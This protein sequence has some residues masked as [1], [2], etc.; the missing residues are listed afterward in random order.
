MTGL[1]VPFGLGET[2]AA[3]ATNSRPAAHA[4]VDTAAGPPVAAIGS[5]QVAPGL[6]DAA[7]AATTIELLSPQVEAGARG[8]PVIAGQRASAQQREEVG[9]T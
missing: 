9:D 1:A 4:I 6:V 8:A 7:F 5:E 3:T 2:R